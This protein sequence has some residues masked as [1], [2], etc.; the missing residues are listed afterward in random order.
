MKPIINLVLLGKGNVGQSWLDLFTEQQARYAGF[1]DV[2]LVAVANSARWLVNKLGL[3]IKCVNEFHQSSVGGNLSQLIESIS[4][5]KINNLVILDITASQEVTDR[6][7][8]FAELGWNIISANKRP[9]TLSVERYKF[10]VGKLNSKNCF[11]G[12]NATVGAALPV[13]ASIQELLHAGDK[14][15]SVS[16][17]FSGSLSYLLTKYDGK[18]SFTELVRQACEA[19]ITE[20]DPRDDLS[21]TDVQRK[22]LILSRISGHI[23]N[24]A[25]IEVS[26]LLPEEFLQGDLND[27]WARK[28]EIDVFMQNAF[29]KALLQ[30]EKLVYLAQAKF[31]GK[32]VQ[33]KVGLQ[34]LSNKNAM[35]QLSPLDNVFSLTTEFYN[36][37][38]LIIRGPGAGA[39]ITATAVNIDLNKF[40]IQIAASAE[41]NQLI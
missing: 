6:Y 24:L 39:E 2:R 36:H 37:N 20:P 41:I 38:P 4:S 14:L 23:I 29:D 7:S 5:W 3:S 18:Q 34:S 27:F 21:G 26:S 40:V 11:W 15:L 12:I 33:G 30:N 17:V 10:L 32:V 19:G 25:D 22:L 1:A 28:V 16:G 13:Q 8:E 31:L 35:S 9:M